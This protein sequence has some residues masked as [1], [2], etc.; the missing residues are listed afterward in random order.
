LS[1]EEDV[2]YVILER[3]EKGILNRETGHIEKYEKAKGNEM[4]W[5]SRTLMFRDTELSA[6]FITL[7]RLY[8]K[9]I[10]IKNDKILS[11]VLTG[12]FEDMDLEE[13][14]DK[15]AISFNLTVLK[16]N[17]TFEISGDGC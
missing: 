7:E 6:V 1:D 5:K 17:D 9:K 15:I 13:I 4:F 16:N 2:A 10:T 8:E 14:L 3:N 12:K 11:C